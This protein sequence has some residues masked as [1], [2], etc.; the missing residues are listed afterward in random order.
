[1][2]T[3]L[4]TALLDHLR[5]TRSQWVRIEVGVEMETTTSAEP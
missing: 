5:G 3:A 2:E 4:R 1:M